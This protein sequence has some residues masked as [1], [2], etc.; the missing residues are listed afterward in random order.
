MEGE[1]KKMKGTDGGRKTVSRSTALEQK[2]VLNGKSLA[3]N[4]V[5]HSIDNSSVKVASPTV[6]VTFLQ[7]L[8]KET[9]NRV[10]K[11]K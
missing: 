6:A 11:C 10:N 8:A 5:L 2:N 4:F 9:C 1:G 7:I 3:L